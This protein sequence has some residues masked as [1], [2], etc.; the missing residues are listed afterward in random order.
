MKISDF[1]KT[2][3]DECEME[4]FQRNLLFDNIHRGK[5]LARTLIGFEL[6]LAI[7]DICMSLLRVDNRFRFNGYLLMYTIMIVINVFYLLFIRKFE[8]IKDVSIKQ[9]K[10]MDIVI[11]I[12]ITL[13][14]SWGSIISMMDQKLY[15]QLIVFMIL[16]ITSSV[17]YY[18]DHKKLLVP[19]FFSVLIVVVCLP[20][21]Q[22]SKDILIGHY[23]NLSTFVIISWLTSRTIFLRYVNDFNNRILLEK[24]NKMLEKEIEVN[25]DINNKLTNA[26]LQLSKLA[27][28]DELTGIPNRRGFRNR[29][30]LAFES[31]KSKKIALSIIMIDIDFFKQFNDNYGHEAGDKA[32]IA[33]ANQINSI[34][35]SSNEY[36]VRWGG[37][38]FI[39]TI[40]YSSKEEIAKLAEI[41]RNKVLE[42]KIR[43]GNSNTD[44]YLT[45]SIGTSTMEISGTEEIS[46]VI[47]LA[48]KALYIAK[49]SGR[50]CIEEGSFDD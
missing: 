20:F 47:D 15:G 44:E 46:N 7:I 34:L 49:K 37:E 10:I 14:M 9:L 22:N 2:N 24:A 38:E 16:M 30:D 28:I 39:Y 42:L 5:T 17:F 4:A 33:V 32:L 19:Y 43:N 50:N 6:I 45:V 23:I 18:W 29:L 3:I 41:I 1:L 26:N 40:F 27:I 35:K 36:F 31:C 12:Y 21:F 11:I 13:I 25:K 48:D 8:N